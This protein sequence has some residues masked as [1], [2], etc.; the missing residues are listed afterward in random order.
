MLRI[1]RD[2]FF[3]IPTTEIII[4]LGFSGTKCVINYKLKTR[5]PVYINQS[6]ESTARAIVI[7]NSCIADIQGNEN[8]FFQ[9]LIGKCFIRAIIVLSVQGKTVS[10]L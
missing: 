10:V 2:K 7:E 8:D 4:A 3:S 6:A 5:E 1:S 9:L